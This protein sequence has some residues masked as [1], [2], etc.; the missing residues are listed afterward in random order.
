MEKKTIKL[1]EYVD[2]ISKSGG[3]GIS[4][5]DNQGSSQS[6]Y[7]KI[8]SR[9]AWIYCFNEN[10]KKHFSLILKKL[11]PSPSAECV[12][13]Y[14]SEMEI[15]CH[16]MKSLTGDYSAESERFFLKDLNKSCEK[17]LGL[18]KKVQ[19]KG[20]PFTMIPRFLP[21]P[22]ETMTEIETAIDICD[23]ADKS[24]KTLNSLSLKIGQRLTRT[25]RGKGRQRADHNNFVRI[26]YEIF[27]SYFGEPSGY[28]SRIFKEVVVGALKVAAG[29]NYEDPSRLI[30]AAI[31][32]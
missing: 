29:I 11:E 24:I 20:M 23:F 32:K 19:H 12:D 17:T 31:K 8:P 1:K 4:S 26:I 3:F 22:R 27:K 7:P 14:I 5:K 30:K 13:N 15:K 2:L 28:K 21:D 18:L 16:L 6:L 9:K 25:E 10:E